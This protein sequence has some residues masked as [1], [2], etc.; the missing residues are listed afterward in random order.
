MKPVI[1]REQ[2]IETQI[3]AIS[4][5]P[6]RSLQAIREPTALGQTALGRTVQR[7]LADRGQSVSP[8]D[9]YIA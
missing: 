9:S 5:L 3:E 7:F 4:D 8:F 1:D 2:E 6:L